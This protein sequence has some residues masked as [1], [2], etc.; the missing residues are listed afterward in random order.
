MSELID[1]AIEETRRRMYYLKSRKDLTEAHR[2]KI[3]SRMELQEIIIAVLEKHKASEPLNRGGVPEYG[4]C[5]DCGA[6]VTKT[7]NPVCCK[8]CMKKLSWT[9]RE[10]KEQ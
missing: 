1:K 10:G 7:A 3:K 9:D 5:P 8:W 2:Q 4:Y 6:V